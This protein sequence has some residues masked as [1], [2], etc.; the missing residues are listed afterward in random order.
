MTDSGPRSIK[1]VLPT[2]IHRASDLPGNPGVPDREARRQAPL[3]SRG[4]SAYGEPLALLPDL[5]SNATAKMAKKL[6]TAACG[7][8]DVGVA[9]ADHGQSSMQS[10]TTATC[11]CTAS[12]ANL[13]HGRATKQ[14]FPQMFTTAPS[15]AAVRMLVSTLTRAEYSLQLRHRA[16]QIDSRVRCAAEGSDFASRVADAAIAD[17]RFTLPIVHE[18]PQ[19]QIEPGWFD[20]VW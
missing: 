19:R 6:R 14:C 8:T 12:S 3:G 13:T 9:R 16:G 2:S 11:V 5:M 20:N 15:G 4:R 1:P 7:P 10:S 18:L 17:H